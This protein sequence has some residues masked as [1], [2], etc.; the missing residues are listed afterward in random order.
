[1]A[2]HFQKVSASSGRSGRFGKVVLGTIAALGAASIYNGR[3]ARAAEARYP[4][5]GRF[6]TVDGVRLHYIDR[7]EGDLIVLVH[8]TG[9]IIQD[10]IT[11]GLIDRLAEHNRVVAFDRPGYGYSDR[12]GRMW[13]TEAQAELLEKALRQLNIQDAVMVGHS[14][15]AQLAAALALR[16]PQLIR[17]LVLISGYFFPT[18][19]KDVPFFSAPAVPL[20]GDLMRY[21]ISPLVARLILPRLIQRMFEP[22]PVAE[23]FDREFP[24]E[25]MLRPSQLHAAAEDSGLMIPSAARLAQRY[26]DLTVPV[27]IIAGSDDQI[28]DVG[29]QSERLHHE[30]P[31]SHLL[32]IPGAGHMVH[33]TAP[34]QVVNAILKAV[35]R[36]ETAPSLAPSEPAL[37]IGVSPAVS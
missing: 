26:R 7:G 8:G 22:A 14:Y 10:F 17:A 13:T 27:T 30:I 18:A 28:V 25:L 32:R 11:S 31:G 2:H 1:M 36:E 35:Q 24:K 23:R 6:L 33:H 19:R 34:D 12:P 21:T 9:T 20:I 16:A 4:P 37:S 5:I 29:R 15:G 3:Q